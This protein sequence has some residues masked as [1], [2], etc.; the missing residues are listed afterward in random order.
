MFSSGDTEGAMLKVLK[1]KKAIGF[2]QMFL[3]YPMH[4]VRRAIR[5]K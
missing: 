1:S 3:M 4:K 5:R 2:D